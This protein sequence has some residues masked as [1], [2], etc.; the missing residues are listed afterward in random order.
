MW[1]IRSRI[2]AKLIRR[3]RLGQVI[4]GPTP[5]GLDR[6]FD[7]GIGCNDHYLK[8]GGQGEQAWQEFQALFLG[9]PQVQQGHFKGLA[10]QEFQGLGTIAGFDGLVSKH[11][12][13]HAERASETRVVVNHEDVH[14]QR[15]RLLDRASCILPD[16]SCI[17]P[18]SS[19]NLQGQRAVPATGYFTHVLSS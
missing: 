2:D 4:E 9:Q 14:G 18:N 16:S 7:G 10:S 12:K 13:R 5:H 3:K 1:A 11:L 15:L 8:S 17:L 19:C 6:R